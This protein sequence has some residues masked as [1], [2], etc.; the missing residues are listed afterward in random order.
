MSGFVPRVVRN[1]YAEHRAQ[2]ERKTQFKADEVEKVYDEFVAEFA[3]DESTASELVNDSV[4]DA[5]SPKRQRV[6]QEDIA[7]VDLFLQDI[8]REAKSSSLPESRSELIISQL[9]QSVEDT[10]IRTLFDA[11]KP[12]VHVKFAINVVLV[13]TG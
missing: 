12:I 7:D 5:R 8:L 11:Y 3:G 2:S 10:H 4:S 9:H 6:V 1:R 13:V